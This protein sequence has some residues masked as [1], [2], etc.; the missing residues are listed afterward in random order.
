MPKR[1][2]I[3]PPDSLKF[4]VQGDPEHQRRLAI[5]G[6][7][8]GGVAHEFNNLL[9][10]ILAYAEMARRDRT[11]ERMLRALDKVVEG[12]Q[13]ASRLADTI[14]TIGSPSGEGV[15]PRVADVRSCAEAALLIATS[16]D[17]C[18]PDVRLDVPQGIL[19]EIESV[20]LQHVLLN[21]V[22]NSAKAVAQSGMIAIRTNRSTCNTS[23]VEITVEDDGCGISLGFLPHV[24]EPFVTGSAK[25]GRGLGLTISKALVEQAGGTICVE[26]TVGEGTIF[27][28]RLA[29]AAAE[30]AEAA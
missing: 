10:P 16:V 7:L 1:E 24:F 25:G 29:R 21:L 11:P 19:V 18:G 26:S 12:M 20:A 22:L 27:T 14:L 23:L 4:A 17:R 9:T 6:T 3:D 8:V 5:L 30:A 2:N 13:Q 28:I 15:G